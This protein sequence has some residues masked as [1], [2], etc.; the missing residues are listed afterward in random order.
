MTLTSELDLDIFT[1]DLHAEIQACMSIRLAR[2]V[3]QTDGHTH[4]HTDTQ[5]DNAKTITPSADAGCKYNLY[6]YLVTMHVS[7]I[8]DFW[9]EV[10]V[11]V[12]LWGREDG[13][14]GRGREEGG[15]GREEEKVS[16]PRYHACFPHI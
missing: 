1:P 2:M 4:T 7:H 5:T 3:R 12:C 8:L 16:V 15:E 6:S 13:K 10:Y 14:R 11:S 9:S